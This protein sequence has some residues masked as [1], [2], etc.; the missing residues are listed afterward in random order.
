LRPEYATGYLGQQKYEVGPASLD[1]DLFK[2]VQ[3]NF[4]LENVKF[5]IEAENFIG[6]DAQVKINELQSV[7]TRKNTTI[8]LTGNYNN[9]PLLIQR[10]TSHLATL[11]YLLIPKI[12]ISIR[13]SIICQIK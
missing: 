8:S 12:Q 7:N 1:I 6:A 5:N 13:T 4:N 9:T 10:A 2:N 3:G 11:V